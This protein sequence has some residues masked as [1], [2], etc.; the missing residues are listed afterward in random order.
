MKRILAKLWRVLKPF[1]KP[2][3][4]EMVHQE[5][6]KLQAELV[7]AIEDRGVEAIPGVI[8]RWRLALA[9]R[10]ADFELVPQDVRL[11]AVEW[12][13]THAEHLTAQLQAKAPGG[14]AVVD[15]VLEV[16]HQALLAKVRAL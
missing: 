13:N 1:I 5:G 9:T 14:R 3:L 7:K 8:F 11:K 16:A 12:V 10:I 15:A 2:Y 6:D 4:V